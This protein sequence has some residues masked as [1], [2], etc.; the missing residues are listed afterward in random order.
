MNKAEALPAGKSYLELVCIA[1]DVDHDD[2]EVDLPVLRVF[3]KKDKK[4]N[5][6]DWSFWSLVE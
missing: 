2:V 6:W 1:E 5:N 4:L 3:Y